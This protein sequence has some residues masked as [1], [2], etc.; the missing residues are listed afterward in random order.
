MDADTWKSL[1]LLCIGMDESLAYT[2]WR[3]KKRGTDY[4]I[5]FISMHHETGDLLVNYV[6]EDDVGRG[7]II[8]RPHS[9][10]ILKFDKFPLDKTS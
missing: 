7:T 5:I 2:K 4:R 10:F 1:E 8:T 9:E 6:T 3:N